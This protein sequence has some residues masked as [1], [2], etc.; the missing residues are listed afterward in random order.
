MDGM[1]SG[2]YAARESL[3]LPGVNPV[4]R[5]WLVSFWTVLPLAMVTGVSPVWGQNTLNK[6]YTDE[7]HCLLGPEI[8]GEADKPISCY[9]RD[10]LTDARYVWQT[11]LVTGKDSNL[12]GIQLDLESHAAKACGGRYNILKA[13]QS[14]DWRWDGPAVMRVYPPDSKIRELKPDRAGFRSVEYMVRLSYV[15][16]PGGATR[17]VS[18]TAPDRLP[19]DFRKLGCP[20]TAVCPK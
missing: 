7:S 15:D 14:K 18:F 10:A 13:T 5:L 2:G 11:Y 3:T 17:I 6:V 9:C 1:G 8:R 16:V 12:Y 20:A 19:P 4:M